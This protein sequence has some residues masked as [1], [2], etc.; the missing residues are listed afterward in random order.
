[1]SSVLA[2]GDIQFMASEVMAEQR[3]RN[4][5]VCG[6]LA[7]SHQAHSPRAH[8]RREHSP[9]ARTRLCA[10]FATTEPPGDSVQTA[11]IGAA[12]HTADWDND[13]SSHYHN[14]K[15]MSVHSAAVYTKDQGKSSS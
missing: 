8:I 13:L 4:L 10:T 1:M 9:R 3:R 5:A 7:K 6:L 12:A 11:V 2:F 14:P 15:P